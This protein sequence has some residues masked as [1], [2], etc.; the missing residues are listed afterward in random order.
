MY[1]KEPNCDECIPKVMPENKEVFDLFIMVRNQHIM[2]FGGPID[3]NFN[4]LKVA[5]E[6]M[7]IE[8]TKETFN[9]VHKLYHTSLA[10]VMAKAEADKDKK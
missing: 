1:N 5:M 3:L 4:S 2:S 9:R 8:N 10:L 7:G 6:A